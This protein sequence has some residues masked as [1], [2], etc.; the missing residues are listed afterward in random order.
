M[1]FA[2]LRFFSGM[3]NPE[4][5]AHLALSLQTVEGDW[6][7]ASEW[8]K[9]ELSRSGRDAGRAPAPGGSDEERKS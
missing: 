8:L 3:S 2:I 4:V 9:R 1:T 6:A 7:H 5:T